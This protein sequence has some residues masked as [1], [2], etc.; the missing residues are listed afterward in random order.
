M[1]GDMLNKV[2]EAEKA[3]AERMKAEEEKTSQWLAEVRHRD[4]GKEGHGTSLSRCNRP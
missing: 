3:I 2:L 1:E 4:R